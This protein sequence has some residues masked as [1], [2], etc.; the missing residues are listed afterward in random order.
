M[1]LLLVVKIDWYV[2]W[3][4]V[5]YGHVN[6]YLHRHWY[7]VKTVKFQLNFKKSLLKKK[8]NEEVYTYFY[9]V[10]LWYLDNFLMHNWVWY[11]LYFLVIMMDVLVMDWYV[12][13]HVP[14]NN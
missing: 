7:L 14:K 13:S 4:F 9:L 6:W 1:V 8:K 12:N 2:D 5:N 11:L 10:V 3:D